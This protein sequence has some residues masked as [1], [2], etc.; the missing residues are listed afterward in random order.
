MKN[1]IMSLLKNL[2]VTDY[3]R[4]FIHIRN[5]L[6]IQIIAKALVIISIPII[7]RLLTPEDFGVLG[8]FDSTIAVMQLLLGLGLSGAIFRYILESTV[9]QNRKE[10]ISTQ[11]NLVFIVNIVIFT[12]LLYADDYIASYIGF[13]TSM[14]YYC[15]IISFLNLNFLIYKSILQADQKSGQLAKLE[16]FANVSKTILMVILIIILENQKYMGKVYSFLVIAGITMGYSFWKLGQRNYLGFILKTRHLVYSLSFALPLLPHQLSAYILNSFDRIIIG[17]QIGFQS[18]GLYS[19]AYSVG[20]LMNDVSQAINRAW[21]PYFIEKMN[22]LD[23]KS[24][25][26]TYNKNH[27]LILSAAFFLFCSPKKQFSY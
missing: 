23:Y 2:I 24:I 10:F 6:S 12:L 3:F 9:H 14:L 19:L 15:Y 22:Q 17:N 20:L 13:P 21:S 1:K 8:L 16:I 7:T 5:Y 4:F 11:L 27:K 25:Q 26:T 18:V